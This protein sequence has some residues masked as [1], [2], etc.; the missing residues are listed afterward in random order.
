MAELAVFEWLGDKE[1]TGVQRAQPSRTMLQPL[2][3]SRWMDKANSAW[4]GSTL[5]IAACRSLLSLV[6]C[7]HPLESGR[8][9]SQAFLPIRLSLQPVCGLR[10]CLLP[11]LPLCRCRSGHPSLQ[12]VS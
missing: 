11:R 10:L 3:T 1:R 5:E 2:L 12:Q 4:A 9:P 8:P 7:E 6:V